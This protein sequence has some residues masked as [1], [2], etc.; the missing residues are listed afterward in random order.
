MH[1]K[2]EI[3][4][5]RDYVD[6]NQNSHCIWIVYPPGAAGDLVASIVNFHYARTGSRFFGITDTGQVIFRDSNKKDFIKNFKIDQT[7]I[8]TTN[9][10]LGEENLNL[11]LMDHVI[12]SNHG[13]RKITIEQILNFFPNAKVIRILP[14]DNIEYSM[15]KWMDEYKNFNKVTELL[16]D[17]NFKPYHSVV[18]PRVLEISFGDLFE[19]TKFEQLYTKIINHLNL[20]YKLIRFDFIKHWISKQHPIIQSKLSS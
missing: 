13:W 19:E 17:D 4:C 2:P 7:F 16:F 12:F 3:E 14:Q 18:H 9:Q 11:S 20:E 10:K 1:Y 8:N 15:A 6:F 5:F